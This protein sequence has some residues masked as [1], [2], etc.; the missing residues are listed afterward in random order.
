VQPPLSVP[1]DEI[2]GANAVPIPLVTDASTPLVVQAEQSTSTRNVSPR[3]Q[4]MPSTEHVED[5]ATDSDTAS[6][7]PDLEPIALEFVAQLGVKDDEGS[8]A[9]PPLKIGG[10][11]AVPLPFDT[12]ASTPPVVLAEVHST[13]VHGARSTCA[14]GGGCVDESIH[15]MLNTEHVKDEATD[16]GTPSSMPDLEPY[17]VELDEIGSA[18]VK[19]GVRATFDMPSTARE[20]M[21]GVVNTASWNPSVVVAANVESEESDAD[22][23]ELQPVYEV[24]AS[25][26]TGKGAGKATKPVGYQTPD[27]FFRD[28]SHLPCSDEQADEEYGYPKWP[29]EVKE[30]GFWEEELHRLNTDPRHNPHLGPKANEVSFA[31][32]VSMLP[33]GKAMLRR[34]EFQNQRRSVWLMQASR[35]EKNNKVREVL[36]ELLEDCPIDVKRLITPVLKY[37]IVETML[38]SVYDHAEKNGLPFKYSLTLPETLAQLK[39]IRRAL[40]AEGDAAAERFMNEIEAFGQMEVQNQKKR[41]K[42]EEKERGRAVID[43][44]GLKVAL[45]QGEV[46]KKRGLMEWKNDNIEEA[47]ASWRQGDEVLRKFRAP[48]KNIS[49]NQKIL[50]LHSAVLK[51]LA[52]AAIRLENWTEAIDAADRVLEM[53]REDLKAWY[54]KATALEGLSKFDEALDCLEKVDILAVDRADQTRINLETNKHRENIELRRMRNKAEQTRMVG[55]SMRRGVFSSK[56]EVAAMEEKHAEESNALPA[57][58]PKPKP[59]PAVKRG[60]KPGEW[61]NDASKSAAAFIREEEERKKKITKDGAFDLLDDLYRAYTD[62]YYVMRVDKLSADVRFDVPEFMANLGN[63]ALEFQ[64]PIL[65]KW[66]FDPSHKGVVEMRAAL[67]AHSRGIDGDRKLRAKAEKVTKA[68]YGTPILGMYKKVHGIQSQ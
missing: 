11:N 51:N 1:G 65:T 22:M 23:P 56:R 52:Q 68:A 36:C 64:I 25:T 50:D 3:I 67:Q 61:R 40:D 37:K 2:G 27:P 58:K 26:E 14:S 46:S 43:M 32:A 54:R 53:N 62:P 4:P 38:I 60:L 47:L 30:P 20:K 63:V 57:R 66:G 41:K 13:S 55:Q 18:D 10:V 28:T 16:S 17:G 29:E 24:P 19:D 48:K 8:N 59:K 15:P 5:E 31:E 33:W 45:E 12:V 49:E 42:I 7:M 21:G 44:E 34:E 9:E 39:N 6:S 35:V